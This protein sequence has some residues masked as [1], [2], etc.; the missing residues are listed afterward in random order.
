MAMSQMIGA[1]V[2][3][4]EDPRLITGNGRYVEDMVRPGT[5]SMAFVRSPHAHARINGIDSTQAR[6]MPGVVAVLT[7][8]DFKPVLSGTHPVAPAFA[9]TKHTVP[10]RFPMAESEVVYQGEAVAVVVADNRKLA[11]DAAQ[12]VQV[13]Y[14]PLTAVTDVLAALAPDSPRVNSGNVDNLGWDM[15]YTS[16]DSV[17]DAFAQAEVVV[18]QRI[19]QQRLAPT[20]IEPRGVM[21]EYSGFE[22]QLTI[23]MTTQNPHLIRLWVSG[24]LGMPE[25]KVRVISHDVGGA[26]GSKISPYPE[27]YLVAATAKILNRPVRWI[28]TRTESLQVTTHGRGQIFDVELAARR[29]GTFLA[30]KVV[31]YLDLGA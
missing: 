25:I 30:L 9:P 17:K 12:A 18:K 3:R 15:A 14:E 4:R 26:F 8:A 27:D 5:L 13:E 6:A 19:L 29:D 20:P 7:A 10:D 24:A 31:Q 11:A 23:W 16:E 21:A 1:R 22:N 28:E 2:Q